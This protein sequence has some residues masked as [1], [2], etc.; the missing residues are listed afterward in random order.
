MDEFYICPKCG[1]KTL[2]G[3]NAIVLDCWKCRLESASADI[4]VE[5]S[6]TESD[7]LTAKHSTIDLESVPSHIQTNANVDTDTY[8][9]ITS[10]TRQHRPRF[11]RSILL[12]VACL[13]LCLIVPSQWRQI[14]KDRNKEPVSEGRDDSFVWDNVDTPKIVPVEYGIRNGE[15][16]NNLNGW[17]FED[18]A[19]KFQ[20]VQLPS[21]EKAL[22]T[23][24]IEQ[25]RTGR[26]YQSF[27][28]PPN[29]HSLSF[30]VHG[31][32]CS[33]IFVAIK[34]ESETFHKVHGPSARFAV[35]K[36]CD[37]R[38][39]REK[40]ITIEIVDYE[41]NPREFIGIHDIRILNAL[42]FAN[43][44]PEREIVETV[45]R[46]APNVTNI[47][48]LSSGPVINEPDQRL[49]DFVQPDE[50]AT[51]I[52]LLK[53][54]KFPDH[55][56]MG[57]WRREGADIVC[58]P[59][60][61]SHF[62]TPISIAGSYQL[63]CR[64]TRESG[65][66]N[67]AIALPVGGR[68]MTSLGFNMH[69]GTVDAL[70]MVDGQH[71][72]GRAIAQFISMGAARQRLS[73]FTNGIEH[74]IV[75]DVTVQDDN[76]A[77]SATL[78]DEQVLLW[79]GQSARLSL[80][81]YHAYPTTNAVGL[82]ANASQVRVHEL[83][84]TA[85]P[86]QCLLIDN[87]WKNAHAP[88]ADGPPESLN[89]QCI[90][91]SGRKYWI[92]ESEMCFADAVAIATKNLGRLLTVSS[93]EEEQFLSSHVSDRIIWMAGRHLPLTNEWRDERNRPLQYLGGWENGKPN[94]DDS[95]G[96]N[97]AIAPSRT[98]GWRTVAPY[99]RSPIDITKHH[100]CIEWGEEYPEGK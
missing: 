41:A 95:F 38:P 23:F 40:M 79:K 67:L 29:A 34:S 13:I 96:W 89:P 66:E 99:G 22:T 68:A 8:A 60:P 43:L 77:I 30:Y 58:E 55:A 53:R 37:I 33:S 98:S 5:G 57:N 12:L 76:V 20:I 82:L 35:R 52:D 92:S 39:L 44:L 91:W 72:H 69:R 18:A 63:D 36:V 62:I 42:E 81:W 85:R 84:M 48:E 93:R 31:T 75:V 16:R 87:D 10:T 80:P 51:R 11:L 54:V 49:S 59:G 4:D 15:F 86:E 73:A 83:A 56:I 26:A 14:A 19:E 100:V 88:M 74:R 90:D 17:Q 45:S 61:D 27:V 64:F 70:S 3:D 50:R 97:L 32:N 94:P 71:A 78:D 46:D 6:G 1:A 65:N 25:N 47:S 7:G 2:I 28:V 21:G 24:G 9:S